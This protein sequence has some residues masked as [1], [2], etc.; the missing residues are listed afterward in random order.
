MYLRQM[1][2]STRGIVLRVTPYSETS[3][4]VNVYTEKFGLQSYM[5]KGARRRKGSMR[6][7]LFR[8]LALLEM[9]VYQKEGK[10]LQTIKEARPEITLESLN[11]D[12]VKTTI[13]LF[14]HEIMVQCLRE[15]EHNPELFGFL[16]E[17]VSTLDQMEQGYLDLHLIFLVRFSR[18]LGFYPQGK[19]SDSS[20]I[21]DLREG[22]F[23]SV[24][25]PHPEFS[26]APESEWI[27]RII[28]SSYFSMDQ[29]NFSTA[30]R[31]KLLDL[32]LHYYEL[33][34]SIPAKF[35]SHKILEQ[36]FFQ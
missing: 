27:S 10:H 15:E 13:A 25:P 9:E 32:L 11:S 16:H 26:E 7:A 5:V 23:A 30:Q 3:L 20:P 4:I 35:R 31:R 33:H 36:I 21:F 24:P 18:F 14:M 17:S 22:N 6:P 29:L 1:I 12:P 8:P 28:R 19:F 2:H 34:L